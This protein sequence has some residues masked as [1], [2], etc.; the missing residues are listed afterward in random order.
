L[1]DNFNLGRRTSV[2]AARIYGDREEREMPDSPNAFNLVVLRSRDLNRAR[3]FY[4]AFGVEF[5]EH[6]HGRA[7]SRA[8]GV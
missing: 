1:T 3:G 5:I 4:R 8:L 2:T 7:R 6:S